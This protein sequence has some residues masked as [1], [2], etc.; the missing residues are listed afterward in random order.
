MD[1]DDESLAAYDV[2]SIELMGPGRTFEGGMRESAGASA[3]VVSDDEAREITA[4]YLAE[5]T[6][7]DRA[8]GRLIDRI[9]ELGLFETSIVIFWSG[10]HGFHLGQNDRWGKW[11]CYTAATHVPLMMSVPGRTVAGSRAPGLVECVD[12]YPTLVELCGLE[13]PPQELE[14]LS[15]APVV[16]DP[17]VPWKHATFAVWGLEEVGERSITTAGYN[18]IDVLPRPLA[19]G[20]VE[21]YDLVEDPSET[22]DVALER[23]DVTSELARRLDEGPSAALPDAPPFGV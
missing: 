10:D 4:R 22:T 12:M 9:D 17:A 2:D 20:S 16:D 21:L 11:S 23:P 5:V 18:Y 15:F 7:M 14:G 8:F 3:E 19:D 6:Q 13:P 1:P